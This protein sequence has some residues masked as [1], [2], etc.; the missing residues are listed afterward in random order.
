MYQKIE[1]KI[2][3]NDRG[4]KAEFEE[5][6]EKINEL[7]ENAKLESQQNERKHNIV[8]AKLE[9][10]KKSLQNLREDM[11]FYQSLTNEANNSKQE[12]K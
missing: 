12:K 4:Y 11:E 9:E 1:D 2:N 8:L 6:K 3:E 5:V 10:L 7:E